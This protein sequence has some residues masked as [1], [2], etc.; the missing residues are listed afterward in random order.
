MK[1]LTYESAMAEL[2][3]L[4]DSLESG[5]LSLDESLEVYAKAIELIK[6]CN[7]KLQDTQKQMTVLV[8]T[9]EGEMKEV[10]FKEED[11]RG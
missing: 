11:Y 10:P 9:F 2:K 4:S 1:N 5:E 3:K 6:L 8:Q 7:K